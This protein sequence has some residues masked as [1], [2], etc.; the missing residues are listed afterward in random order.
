VWAYHARHKVS[1]REAGYAIAVG[2]VARALEARGIY[3]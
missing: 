2:R 1:L 3:P